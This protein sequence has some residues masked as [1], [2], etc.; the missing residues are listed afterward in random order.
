MLQLLIF[1]KGDSSASLGHSERCVISLSKGV[2]MWAKSPKQ[3]CSML[4]LVP[5]SE[6][7]FSPWSTYLFSII[8][9]NTQMAE[10][11]SVCQIHTR[12]PPAVPEFQ[13]SLQKYLSILAFLFPTLSASLFLAFSNRLLPWFPLSK[14]PICLWLLRPVNI[15]LVKLFSNFF[16]VHHSS[17]PALHPTTLLLLFPW[18]SL[19]QSHL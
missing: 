6:H 4:S 1:K 8:I 17:S 2:V 19:L 15:L 12:F 14:C 11:S 5:A 9:S 3:S 18:T 16:M 13:Q 7:L 10:T